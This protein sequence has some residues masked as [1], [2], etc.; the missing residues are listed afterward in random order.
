[1]KNKFLF[2]LLAGM[3]VTIA[4]VTGCSSSYATSDQVM[5]LQ[6]QVNS[7]NNSLNST[8]QDLASTQ[9]QL[10]TAQQSLS[11]AQSNQQQQNTYTTYAQPRVLYQPA[12][13]APII[14]R[15]YPYVTQWYPSPWHQQP[16]QLPHTPAPPMP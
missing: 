5:T 9:Q 4:T 14:V 8:Q 3:L 6:N 12:Y 16:P 10:Q 1:M 13:Q 7:L 2:I 15:T 11:Q